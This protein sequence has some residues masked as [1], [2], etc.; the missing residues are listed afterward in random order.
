MLDYKSR[1]SNLKNFA[2]DNP[3]VTGKALQKWRDKHSFKTVKINPKIRP[4]ILELWGTCCRICGRSFARGLLRP[5]CHHICYDPE[6]IV[7]VCNHCHGLIHGKRNFKHPIFNYSTPDESVFLFSLSCLD[8]LDRYIEISHGK[9]YS[10]LYL[11]SFNK[12]TDYVLIG[13]PGKKSYARKTKKNE[14]TD[15]IINRRTK[16]KKDV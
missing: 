16:I 9:E 12:S 11:V 2:F 5:I 7:V 10:K 6:K 15:K 14:T 4:S 8:M 3:H 1:L 13:L